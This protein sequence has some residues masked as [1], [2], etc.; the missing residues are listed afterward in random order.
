M[1]NKDFESVQSICLVAPNAQL[2]V[3]CVANTQTNKSH[4]KFPTSS[5][6]SFQYNTG[7]ILKFWLQ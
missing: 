3:E 7:N 6:D 4:E 5:T 1:L 2:A